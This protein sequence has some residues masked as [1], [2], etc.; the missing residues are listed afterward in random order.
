MIRSMLMLLLDWPSRLHSG[1]G[2]R[3]VRATSDEQAKASRAASG[4]RECRRRVLTSSFSLGSVHTRATAATPAATASDSTLA[5][6][7][8]ALAVRCHG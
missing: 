4:Q 1:C 3:Q 7:T 6:R 2:A 8:C 5:S